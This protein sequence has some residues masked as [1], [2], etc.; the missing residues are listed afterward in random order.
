[1]RLDK[2]LVEMQVGSRS[3]VKKLLKKGLVMVNEKV[4]KDGSQ[5]VNE[6]ED[7][8]F[9]DGE[10]LVYQKYVYY[11]LHKP[12]GVISATK[13]S[14][15][16]VID[17]L[18]K[19]DY[20]PDVFPVGR[21]DKD[22]EGLLLLTNDGPLAHE[23][24]SPKKHVEKEYFAR[25]FGLVTEKEVEI[26]KK[27]FE[28]DGGEKVLPSELTIDSVDEENHLSEIRLVIHEGKYHQVKRM[29]QAQGM[30]VIY[31]KRL[32]MGH[33][34]LGDLTIGSYQKLTETE[35]KKSAN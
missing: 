27:G 21:L 26:F 24:L 30:K 20:R 35:I 22:T 6:T 8:I 2:F 11:L 15:K 3:E 33:L 34:T 16:T 31:L 7:E 4:I 28:I 19:E 12:Q 18:S 23:L 10:K 5:H 17:L 14:Q 32:R 1:M 9:F 25:V 13:D 29:F